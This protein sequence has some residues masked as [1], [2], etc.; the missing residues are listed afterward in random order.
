MDDDDEVPLLVTVPPT[1]SPPLRVVDATNIVMPAGSKIPITIITGF[2]GAGKS[3]LL[4]YI[5]TQNHNKKIAVILNE[6]GEGQAVEKSI[7][8]GHDGA[9]FEE[10]LELRNGC[11]CCSVKDNGLQAVENL[12]SKRGLFDY[13]LLETTGLADP[14]PIAGMF[15]VD[16]ALCSS[17]QLDGIVTLVDA[18]HCLQHLLQVPQEGVL[19]EAVKQVA[20]ADR[21]IIN[22]IDLVSPEILQ[23]VRD[24]VRSINS[25]ARCIET[26]RA[27]IDLEF[28]LNLG[29]YEFSQEKILFH[30]SQPHKHVDFR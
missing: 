30:M 5:L 14:A 3:T 25:V 24:A 26:T 13:I 16:A 27:T 4:N 6:F 21:I 17:V 23:Q 9:L 2:L 28:V 11:L 7:H 22:K 15:W 18:R 10:W 12:M 8:V 1:F 29:A 19:N 20:L